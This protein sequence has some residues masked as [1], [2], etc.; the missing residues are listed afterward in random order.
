MPSLTS[1]HRTLRGEQGVV[2]GAGEGSL[3]QQHSK[4]MSRLSELGSSL[5]ERKTALKCRVELFQWPPCYAN[6]RVFSALK[7]LPMPRH[8][9]V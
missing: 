3:L 1:H 5:L 7:V 8:A 2:W 9:S 6:K 4:P